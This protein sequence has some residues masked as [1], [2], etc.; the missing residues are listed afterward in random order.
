MYNDE[1]AGGYLTWDEPT[2]KGVYFDGRLEVYDTPFFSAYLDNMGNIDAW[3]RDADA[4]GIQSAMIFHR[5]GNRHGFARML[6]SSNWKLVYYDET[7]AIFVRAGANDDV[8]RKAQQAF[9][10]T[11][12]PKTEESLT[13]PPRAFPWQ[14]RIDRYT[15]ELAYARILETVG[16]RAEAAKWFENAIAT[17]M[18]PDYEIEA[19]QHVASYLAATGQ[20]AQARIQLVKALEAVPSDENTRSMLT[21]LDAISHEQH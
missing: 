15:G 19:R 14:W 8:I 21:R 16:E 17:G 1:T 5:W 6:M 2:G 11:W 3:T 4:R 18:T 7:A 13:H 12:R 9:L 20:Y 10:S